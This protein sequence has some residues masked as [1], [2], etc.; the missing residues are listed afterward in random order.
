MTA[1]PLALLLAQAGIVPEWQ[2]RRDIPRLPEQVKKLLPLLAQLDPQAWV[3]KGASPTY[4][5]QWK[6]AQKEV[7]YLEQSSARLAEQPDKLTF[8]LDVFFR[9]QAIET[10]M[11]SLVE[12]IRKY[13]NPALADLLQSIAGENLT[14]KAGL[15]QY[16]AEVAEQRETEW[17]VMESEAQRCRS[18]IAAPPKAAPAPRPAKKQ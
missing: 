14:V 4:A 11:G 3:S 7:E 18:Q 8:A 15:Q 12:A 1:L 16:I 13:Q 9:L 5:D 10:R 2:A 6:S 17:R